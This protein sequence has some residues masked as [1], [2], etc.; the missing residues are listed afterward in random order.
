[1]S[2]NLAFG[3]FAKMMDLPIEDW[4]RMRDVATGRAREHMTI[5]IESRR[6]QERERILARARAE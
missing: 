2:G 6:Y 5:A 4:E 1:M 3:P